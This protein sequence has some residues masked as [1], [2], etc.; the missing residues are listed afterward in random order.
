VYRFLFLLLFF[1]LNFSAQNTKFSID[2]SLIKKA[3]EIRKE[4]EDSISHYDLKKNEELWKTKYSEFY[5]K[6]IKKLTD[7]YEQLYN[8]DQVSTI[9]SLNVSSIDVEVNKNI[10]IAETQNYSQLLD[11]NLFL[12]KNFPHEFY[13]DYEGKYTC[14]LDFL[15]DVDGKFKK[16]KYSG[17][18]LE[19]NLLSAIYMYSVEKLEKPLLYK[20]KAIK[21]NFRQPITLII[22]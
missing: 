12:Q 4:C 8:N 10:A 9:E 5:R 22:E 18:K 6:K 19:F 3:K 16:I 20:N 13:M 7:L 21:G 2:K 11:L 14:K 15:V 17:E 1:S